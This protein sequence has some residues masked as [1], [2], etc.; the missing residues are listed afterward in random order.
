VFT[1]SYISDAFG[2]PGKYD[3]VTSATVNLLTSPSPSINGKTTV[4]KGE[5]GVMYNVPNLSGHSYIWTVTN[6]A[7]ASGQ[8]TN[9]ITV[10]WSS[11]ASSGSVQVN[12]MIT[13]TGCLMTDIQNI[14]IS[15]AP[16]PSI[17]G[18]NSVCFGVD[19]NYRTA[20]AVDHAFI[21]TVIGGSV[22]SGQGTNQVSVNWD[23]P[24]TGSVTVVERV[25]AT[26]VSGSNTLNITVHSLPDNSL[27]VTDTS[28][29]CTGGALIVKVKNGEA[30]TDYTLRLNSNNSTISTIHNVSLGD[31]VFTVSPIVT[32]IYNV[33]AVNQY[34]CN[35][36]LTD[37]SEVSLTPPLIAPI[38][39]DQSLI[40][41][42]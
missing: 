26:G 16:T 14:V 10:N 24:G 12:E 13:A 15:N 20:A 28:T 25:I 17:V 7:I 18:N 1:I 32:T 11:S 41:R 23:T 40:R 21:W 33:L 2:T 8:N 37:L 4:S 34:S 30:N 38:Q 3:F 39:S 35:S 6:G 27:V 5:N 29:T 42:P 31:V 9:Q 19:E 22:T 36:V